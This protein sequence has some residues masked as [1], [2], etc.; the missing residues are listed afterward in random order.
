ME[1]TDRDSREGRAAL[2][3]RLVLYGLFAG[4]A[5]EAVVW[6][7]AN[8][9]L[10]VFAKEGGPLEIVQHV[11]AIA[12]ACLFFAAA[13]RSGARRS[14]LVIA[15]LCALL[16]VAREADHFFDQVI[17]RGG[18]T[19]F[20]WP[21]GIGAIAVALRA[22]DRLA[23]QLLS[24]AATPAFFFVAFAVFVILVYG[25]IVGQKQLWQAVMGDGYQRG[26]KDSV[27]EIQELLGYFMFLFASIEALILERRAAAAESGGDDS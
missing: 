26:V 24:F 22:R 18:Y 16:A 11:L 10:A 15:G 27:E 21:L 7:S 8:Y 2:L 13:A 25:Q 4:L 12:A 17:G 3:G 20:T 6:A 1:D 14:L 19:Y 9:P 5:F 23:G